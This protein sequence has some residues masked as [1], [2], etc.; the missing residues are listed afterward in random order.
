MG[1]ADLASW[2]AFSIKDD[3]GQARLNGNGYRCEKFTSKNAN[4]VRDWNIL[5][6]IQPNPVEPSTASV[7]EKDKDL[8]GFLGTRTR[9][10]PELDG[11]GIFQTQ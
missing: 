6:S 7:V 9:K 3:P 11:F 1:I 8:A 4:P 10:Q 5:D 2:F